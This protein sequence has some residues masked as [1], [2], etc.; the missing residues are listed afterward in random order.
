MMK[1]ELRSVRYGTACELED[2]RIGLF[3]RVELEPDG[4]AVARVLV[5]GCMF[6]CW[7]MVENLILEENPH[8]N[9]RDFNMRLR[10]VRRTHG[11]GQR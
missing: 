4:R 10:E 2:G 1:E 8:P 7:A 6:V 5:P 11:E 9:A 3:E